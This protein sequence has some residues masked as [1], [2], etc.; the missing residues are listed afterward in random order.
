MKSPI[1][2]NTLCCHKKGRKSCSFTEK[3]MKLGDIIL[4]KISQEQKD[5]YKSLSLR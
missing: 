5:K 2:C 1:K 3:M 4:G